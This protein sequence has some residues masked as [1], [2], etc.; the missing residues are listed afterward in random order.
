MNINTGLNPYSNYANTSISPESIRGTDRSQSLTGSIT[1]SLN[2]GDVFEGTVNSVE[3]G[4]VTIGLANGQTMTARLDTGV[5]I[6]PGQSIFFQVKS[7]D[8][9]LVQIKPVS[10]NSLNAN[11]TLLKA[12]SM[13]GLALNERTINMVN[14]M[15]KDSLPISTESLI[16]MN[17]AML[18]NPGVDVSTLSAMNKLDIPTSPANVAMFNN[19]LADAAS[20]KDS[21][22]ALSQTL[23][24]IIDGSEVPTRDLVNI[25]NAIR[26]IFLTEE[27]INPMPRG[28]QNLAQGQIQ[29]Q[30]MG[31]VPGEA[32]VQNP[33]SGQASQETQAQGQNLQGA[34]TSPELLNPAA[35]SIEIGNPAN[36]ANPQG[37]DTILNMVAG[38]NAEKIGQALSA[39]T[40]AKVA[41]EAVASKDFGINVLENL[42][43]KEQIKD[44]DS[45]LSSLKDFPKDNSQVFDQK[46]NLRLDAPAKE[47]FKEISQ[48]INKTPDSQ[49][50]NDL[51]KNP[52]Y[53]SLLKGIISD[54][55]SM[56]PKDIAK[57][58]QMPKLYE[59]VLK[60][61]DNLEQ[62]LNN[63]ADAKTA[64]A[65]KNEIT[66]I[67]QNIQFMD[68]ANEMY[69]FIQIP[70]KMY[71][72]DTE[73]SLYVRQNKKTSYEEGEEITAFLHFDLQ[74]LGPTDVFVSLIQKKVDCKW[75]LASDEALALIEENLDLLNARLEAKGYTISSELTSGEAKVD[76]AKDFLG[77][78][79]DQAQGND[80]LVHRYSFDMRA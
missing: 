32:L 10:L 43:S 22:S 6:S 61:L 34:K 31:Q 30:D 26:D 21:F 51:I 38:E 45:L 56:E 7:N 1:D 29:G 14:S 80:E 37:A 4:K 71:N 68:S 69:N 11:P 16:S 74:Y 19:Y 24:N 60:S 39:L 12:L 3:N 70:L 75:N 55:F 78:P 9:Q 52:V 58:G 54:A 72:Q 44:M 27:G 5:T 65:S 42:A 48:F 41:E 28:E 49:V 59:K 8:G 53:K 50:I 64:A 66:N 76:F 33:E 47:L 62:V 46:G 73:G 40:G 35:N 57:E 13:A 18:N 77:L 20:I 2:T 23:T 63:M 25:N 36:I 17:R 67:R 15:M 79:L